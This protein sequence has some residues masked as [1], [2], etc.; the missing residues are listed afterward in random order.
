MPTYYLLKGKRII[1]D[2]DMSKGDVTAL[3]LVA[4]NDA[5]SLVSADK[6]LTD[7]PLAGKPLM[8]KLM[9]LGLADAR[10][11]ATK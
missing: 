1:A 6:V 11:K 3:P 4:D 7:E 2:V 5:M 9:Y 8:A 10:S